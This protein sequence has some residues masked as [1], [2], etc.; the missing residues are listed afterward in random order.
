MIS[1]SLRTMFLE[2]VNGQ[3]LVANFTFV[4]FH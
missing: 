2:L 1:N 3:M 4:H